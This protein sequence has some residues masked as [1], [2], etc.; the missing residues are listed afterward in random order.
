MPKQPRRKKKPAGWDPVAAWY[1]GWVG[2]GGSKHHRELAIPLVMELLDPQPGESVLDVGAGQGVLAPHITSA[3]AKY[4]GVDVSERLL[5]S[6]RSHHGKQGRFLSGDARDLQGVKGLEAGS[7]DAAVF[8]LSI[9]DIDPLESALESVDWALKDGGRVIILMTHP[10]FRIPRQSG[11]GWD[12]N[13]KLQY[14]RIDRYLTPLP[15][16]MKSYTGQ[17]SGTTI[18]FHRPLSDYINGLARVGL[19]V[20]ALHEIPT[21]KKS[22]PGPRSKAENLANEEIPVFAGLRARK[23]EG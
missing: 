16:P 21:Y 15:V 13:R 3:G 6:A 8:L 1:D 17:K 2:K 5:K 11:W 19:L 23:L 18:S 9:Q 14:R 22:R 12:E 4:T 7:F 10:C 20:D